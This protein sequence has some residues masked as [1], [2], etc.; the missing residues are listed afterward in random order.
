[1]SKAKPD[2]TKA[3]PE[4]IKTAVETDLDEVKA[5]DLEATP[6]ETGAVAERQ[7]IR[8]EEPAM[9]AIGALEDRCGDRHLAVRR[10]GRPKKRTQGDGESRQKLAVACGQ[11]AR[12]TVPALRKGRSRRG[13]GKTTGNG[14]RGRS[15]R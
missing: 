4:E 5:T 14:I 12:R 10:C 7:E 13:P 15:T 6:E 2:K 11:L 8:K 3:V 1:M 9:E